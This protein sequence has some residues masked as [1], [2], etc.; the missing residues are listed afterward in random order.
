M[1]HV[2]V[3]YAA[4]ESPKFLSIIFL[5]PNISL[6]FLLLKHQ[7]TNMTQKMRSKTLI[8]AYLL[9]IFSFPLTAQIGI[10]DSTDLEAF[11]DGIIEGN[12]EA[13]NI[14][15]VT[16]AVVKD[17]QLFFSKG[18]GLADV[19][20]GEKVNS[21]TTLFRIGSVS[22][23]FV[24]TAVMQL[25][26]QGKLDLD[27][28][29]NQYLNHFKIPDTYEQPITLKHLMTHSAGFEEYILNLFSTDTL[30]PVSLESIFQAEMPTRVRPPGT[31]SAYSNHGT[32]I[33]AYIVE[34]ISGLKWE[35]YVEQKIFA[36]LDMKQSSFRQ[37]LPAALKA[38]HAKGYTYG[39]GE[40]DSQPLK[41]VPLG[42]VGIA[43]MTANDISKFMIAHLQKGKYGGNKILDSLTAVQMHSP[44]FQHAPNING[45]CYG[46]FDHSEN[47]H[48]IIGHGGATE[49]F[50]SMLLIYPEQGTGIFISTNSMGGT[51][52]IRN[53]T[54]AF[55]NRYF[56]ATVIPKTITLSKD[57]LAEFEGVYLSNRRPHNR[58]TKMAALL[59][60]DV[61][62]SVTEDG[63]LKTSGNPVRTWTPLDSMTFVN[64]ASDIKLGFRRD[65]EG[66]VQHAFTSNAP[67]T[68]L[69]RVPTLLSKGLHGKLFF[70]A[71]GTILLAFVIWIS[72][73]FYKWYYQLTDEEDL[74]AANKKI[75]LVNGLFIIGFLIAFIAMSDENA[76]I[77]RKRNWTDYALFSLPLFSLLLTIWQFIKMIGVWKLDHVRLRSR[78]FYT[79][80]T[81]GFISLMGQFYYW[82]LLG[83][84]F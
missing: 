49:F 2:C 18:Y 55:T 46:F 7:I 83:F 22:K 40:Y 25:A 53:T 10:P 67:H 60:D 21:E 74:P 50:F 82:N 38:K 17:N 52:L 58:F 75:A 5:Y 20:T 12:M 76:M 3:S 59:F 62:I 81:L 42:P 73:H 30:P 51:S 19:G 69:D 78:L 29:V 33:A 8:L 68:A 23:L 84:N 45:M 56:P 48:K 4:W 70:I 41:I 43:S 32:G 57:Y 71:F 77:F 37:P 54:T 15:G 26:E 27:A 24:W 35:E 79:L 63:L 34:Q 16:V 66:I 65:A 47:G 14:A 61:N 31:F 44:L 80:L 28:D 11:L 13:R 1:I 72:N 39:G 64:L 36:P 9:T 6:P